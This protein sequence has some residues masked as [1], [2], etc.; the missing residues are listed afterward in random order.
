MVPMVADITQRPNAGHIINHIH[1]R[2]GKLNALIAPF[3]GVWQT[4]YLTNLTSTDT[5]SDLFVRWREA[6]HTTYLVSAWLET[7]A[8][9]IVEVT[10]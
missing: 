1:R 3:D 5:T 8:P 10:F 2:F 4:L 9:K 7:E 6:Q